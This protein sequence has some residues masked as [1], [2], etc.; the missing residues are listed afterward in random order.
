[1][2]MCLSKTYSN[3][4]IV[5]QFYDGC[6]I[7]NDLK[8]GDALS[9]LLSNFTLEH[10]VRKVHENQVGLKLNGA[11]QLLAYADDVNP[12]EDSIGTI[13][14]NSHVNNVFDLEVKPKKAEYMLVSR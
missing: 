11:H 10:T 5:K 6:P 8:P 3:G 4:C 1:M 9:P 2:K 12:L 14:K 7:Q 13:K